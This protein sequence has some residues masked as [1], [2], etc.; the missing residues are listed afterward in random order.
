MLRAT[1]PGWSCCIALLGLCHLGSAAAVLG[2]QSLFE[3][4][5]HFPALLY[6]QVIWVFLRCK[7]SITFADPAYF[8]CVFFKSVL[9]YVIKGCIFRNGVFTC[10]MKCFS[11][12]SCAS[13]HKVVSSMW[14]WGFEI[15]PVKS[16]PFVS[17][18]CSRRFLYIVNLDAP[19]EGHRKISR[20]SKW[21]IGAVQWNPHD[22]YA[23]YF[24]ASVSSPV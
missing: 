7:L 20:Q 4:L 11:F 18:S 12:G 16:S 15:S 5:H 9:K 17:V 10:L 3:C 13:R 21:D 1:Y 24:A 19:N 22:S 14:A 2:L 8:Q 6:I 23:Y